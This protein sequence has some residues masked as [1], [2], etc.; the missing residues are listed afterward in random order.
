MDK[1]SLKKLQMNLINSGFKDLN[2]RM[3]KSLNNIILY[4]E[5]YSFYIVLYKDTYKITVMNNNVIS[6]DLLSFIEKQFDE[7]YKKSIE[8]KQIEGEIYVKT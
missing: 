4:F 7:L 6:R 3:F 2:P 5:H 8:I 1:E